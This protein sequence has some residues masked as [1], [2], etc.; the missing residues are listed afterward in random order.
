MASSFAKS[1]E[2]TLASGRPGLAALLDEVERF[3]DAAPVPAA[4]AQS[5]MIA[6]DEA[7]SNAIDHGGAESGVTPT[8]DLRLTIGEGRIEGEVADSGGAF[9][10]LARG[11]PD[12][13]LALEDRAIGGL[14]VLLIRKLM[15]RV[16]YAREEGRNRLRFSKTFS[17]E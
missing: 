1:F 5:M 6:C 13:T 12:T 14:G 9:D 2:R 16:S 4:V 10:P 17:I 8:V 7:I 15:D 3:L 11:D